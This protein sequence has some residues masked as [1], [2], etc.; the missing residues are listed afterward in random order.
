MSS[1]IEPE[2]RKEDAAAA[3]QELYPGDRGQL[4]EDARRLLV[5]LLSGPSVDGRRH[6]RL[7]PALLRYQDVIRSRLADL[8]LELI[9][10]PDNQVAFIRQADTGELEAPILLRR[11]RLTFLESALLLHLRQLLAEADMRGER[12]VVAYQ[13]MV[14]Q[15]KLYEQT[16]NTDRAGFDKRINAAIEKVKKNSL[17]STIRGSDDRYEIAPTLK[18]LFSAEEIAAL[19]RTY[20]ASR[21][22]AEEPDDLEEDQAP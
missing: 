14:E 21:E 7:W 18:L 2:E 3:Q 20:A 9:L 15:M 8:F 6:S 19:A 16:L 12:A 17:I 13:E 22:E 10:D 4:P 1:Q 5:Q 11:T